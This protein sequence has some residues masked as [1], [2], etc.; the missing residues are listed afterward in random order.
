LHFR[1]RGKNRGQREIGAAIGERIVK[2]RFFY[3]AGLTLFVA[4]SV[5]DFAQ[6]YA[7]IQ[8]GDGSVYEANPVA[9]IW[10]ERYGWDGLAV[11]KAATV[12]VLVGAVALLARRNRWAAT[13]V[14][15]F[16][17]TAV[18]S[19]ALHSQRLLTELPDAPAAEAAEV[20][21]QAAELR[22]PIT[23]A[24]FMHYKRYCNPPPAES[25]PPAGPV[26]VE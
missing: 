14:M 13:G 10:L 24:E 9:A 25:I 22:R 3:L 4:L 18:L 16:A 21:R 23:R 2:R 19:V 6:T 8:G 17:C 12:A 11:F 5:T 20:E 15:G 7:L 26:W 1:V